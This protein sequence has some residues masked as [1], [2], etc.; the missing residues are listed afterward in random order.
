VRRDELRDHT[1]VDDHADEFDEGL[2]DDP[3]GQ[4]GVVL[5]DW[6]DIRSHSIRNAARNEYL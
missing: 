5:L 1:D 2:R 6:D 3:A 4:Q